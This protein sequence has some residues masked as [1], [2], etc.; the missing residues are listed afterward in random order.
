[1][2]RSLL[3]VGFL[4]F[5]EHPCEK[6]ESKPGNRNTH[7]R[8]GFLGHAEKWQAI[9]YCNKIEKINIPPRRQVMA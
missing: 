3:I 6:K 1:M 9:I 2:K 7:R 8:L 5:S 4:I